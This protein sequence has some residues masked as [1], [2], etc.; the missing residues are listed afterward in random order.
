VLGNSHANL[1]LDLDIIDAKLQSNSISLATRGQNIY[2]SYYCALEAYKYQTPE[3]LI[4]ENFLFYER[5]TMDAF[6]NQDPTINDY[7]KRY[8]TYEGKKFGKVKIQESKEFFKG[9]IMENM[10]PL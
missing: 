10:F 1:G 7:M 2:Q 6:I 8:L 5:L 3:V 4:I 9:S